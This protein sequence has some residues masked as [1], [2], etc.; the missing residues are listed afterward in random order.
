MR[1]VA[2]G[3]VASVLRLSLI[4]RLTTADMSVVLIVVLL[5]I[6][7]AYAKRLL[8][9]IIIVVICC[10]FG[11]DHALVLGITT[12]SGRTAPIRIATTLLSAVFIVFSLRLIV[13]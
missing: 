2:A 11:V 9:V 4:G 1:R 6:R 10:V 13:G 5:V 7:M 12:V 3:P 8:R